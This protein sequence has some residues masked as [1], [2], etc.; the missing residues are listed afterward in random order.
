[1]RMRR[2][3][4]HLFLAV[5]ILASETACSRW[6][7]R[8]SSSFRTRFPA[9]LDVLEDP[10][11]SQQELMRVTADIADHYSKQLGIGSEDFHWLP[12]LR[13]MLRREL[14]DPILRR[15]PGASCPVPP[16]HGCQLVFD[17]CT[18]RAAY[19]AWA[20]ES[21]LLGWQLDVDSH[22]EHWVEMR[23]ALQRGDARLT[24]RALAAMSGSYNLRDVSASL[25]GG[26]PLGS[27]NAEVVEPLLQLLAIPEC[28][29]YAL[30]NL[31]LLRD[32]A[33]TQM[34]APIL[35]MIDAKEKPSVS[36]YSEALRVFGSLNE[37]E[38]WAPL[39][40]ALESNHSELQL[41]AL[42][43][44]GKEMRQRHTAELMPLLEAVMKST[45][46]PDVWREAREH[47]WRIGFSRIGQPMTDNSDSPHLTA[48]E[49][50]EV[51][52]I[53]FAQKHPVPA[54]TWLRCP[55]MKELGEDLELEFGGETVLLRP[56]DHSFVK[57]GLCSKL[58]DTRGADLLEPLGSACIV[59]HDYG[60]FGG[61]FSIREKDS[62]SVLWQGV[63]PQR[64]VRPQ[65]SVALLTGIAHMGISQGFLLWLE[66]LGSGEW[67][68]IRTTV[69]PGWVAFYGYTRGGDL[70]LAIPDGEDCSSHGLFRGHVLRVTSDGQL[71]SGQ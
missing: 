37:E 54:P 58:P 25:G 56:T 70:I 48:Y 4:L 23:A 63:N 38:A 36:L 26:N 57:K 29:L 61:G 66:R 8:D 55:R 21:V 42:K 35:A 49:R 64:L 53:D 5:L 60:E 40:R 52:F 16:A 24:P 65:G 10:D 9:M 47:L 11:S 22:P 59:G 15:P 30:S 67:R 44:L 6:S 18:P 50:E 68:I 43:G 20:V 27:N 1:M 33:R 7:R 3:F 13:A 46:S 17:G 34:M 62:L 19:I 14:D 28:R 39:R 51:N 69:L 2:Y 41:T 45:R 31:E 32:S 12:R 71:V